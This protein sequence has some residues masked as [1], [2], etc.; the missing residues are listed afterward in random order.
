[1]AEHEHFLD[2][3]SIITNPKL[4]SHIW[5]IY[6]FR[7]PISN[8]INNC[9]YY[10]FVDKLKQTLLNDEGLNIIHENNNSTT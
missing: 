1:M 2:N 10:I 9:K 5:E 7:F 4:S 3:N 8:N 6:I